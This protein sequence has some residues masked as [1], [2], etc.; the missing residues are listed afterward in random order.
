MERL[1]H[2]IFEFF[3]LSVLFTSFLHERFQFTFKAHLTKNKILDNELQVLVNSVEML[4]FLLH[5]S[6]HL[7][8]FSDFHFSGS[9]V[10]F[11]FFNFVI[12]HK[13]EL[14]ELLSLFLEFI[15]TKFFISHGLF[16]ILKF[17]L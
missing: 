12:K 9:N 7:L 15:N 11:E 16:T 10:S 2:I 17:F 14:F 3:N 5:L 8:K 13:L 6:S 1:I 4:N